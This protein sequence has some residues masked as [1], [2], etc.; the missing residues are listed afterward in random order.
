MSREPKTIGIR[1][2]AKDA[3]QYKM[4]GTVTCATVSIEKKIAM[5]QSQ[6]DGTGNKRVWPDNKKKRKGNYSWEPRQSSFKT[7]KDG[8]FTTIKKGSKC[9]RKKDKK[10]RPG[11]KETMG[12][13]L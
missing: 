13:T 1:G 6:E 10:K 5:G 9:T 12:G 11:W 2:R 3:P 8:M 4:R 7:W